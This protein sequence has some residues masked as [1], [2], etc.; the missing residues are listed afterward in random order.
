ML[1]YLHLLRFDV[2]GP[3]RLFE[4]QSTRAAV[5]AVISFLTVALIVRP[6]FKFLG[7]KI[8]PQR[9]K[10][11]VSEK[12][13]NTSKVPTMGG[14]LFFVSTI[15]ATLL[16]ARPNVYVYSVLAVF[17]GMS[18]VGL[19][20]DLKKVREKKT[21]GISENAKWIGLTLSALVGFGILMLDGE[22]RGNICEF[23]VPFFPAPL[24]GPEAST[25]VFVTDGVPAPVLCLVAALFYWLVTVGCSNAVNLTDGLDGL[26]AGCCLPNILTFGIIA[27]FA[28]NFNWANYLNIN[29]IPGCGELAVFCV[30]LATG[31]AA[32][33][34]FN[35]EPAEIYM[36]DVGALGI[37][38][39]IGAVAVVS[40][41]PLLLVVAG[42]IFVA[43]AGS[44][45]L[46][47]SYFKYYK[48]KE[49]V[50]KRLF[51]CT[52]I[53]HHFQ[54]KDVAKSKIVLRMWMIT[55]VCCI[56]AL[57]TLKLR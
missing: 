40:G 35:G 53:H 43:E 16:A 41:Q 56:I 2:W 38:G 45:I 26:A 50:G 27:Y 47:R 54:A 15:V 1:Y 20:D 44:V 8:Q 14:I 22:A 28:G 12:V 13:A 29:F 52:P 36:G 24:F 18:F 25:A 31:V 42:L 6:L 32:F 37:G 51:A 57:L 10:E 55:S 48:Y 7:N 49:G 9:D 19:L 11:S 39:G 30:A 23:W 17:A 21:D 33:L 4:Y 34:W 46:Q 3:L 5:A